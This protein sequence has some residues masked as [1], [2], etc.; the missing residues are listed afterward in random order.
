MDNYFNKV[1][2]KEGMFIAPQHF[3]QQ[4]R[5]I[6]KTISLGIDYLSESCLIGVTEL[7]INTE[8]LS[9]GKFC[10]TRC[11]GI[12]PDKTLFE[13][14]QE[15]VIDIDKTTINEIIY[16]AL[17]LSLVG[18]NEFSHK[19]K[20]TKRYFTSNINVFDNANDEN[21]NV[22]IDIGHLN[23]LLKTENQ[24]KSG[25]TLLPIAKVLE[26]KN[27]GEVIL[28]RNYI[29]ACIHH[30]ASKYINDKLRELHTLARYRSQNLMLRIENN[31][32]QQNQQYLVL[33]YIWLQTLNSWI[34]WLE[35]ALV[36]TKLHVSNIYLA[37][38][39]FL[40][41]LLSL[42][43][44]VIPE[45][46]QLKYD[47]LYEN[48][49]PLFTYLR[50]VLTIIQKETVIEHD[51]NDQLFAKR[52]I[53]QLLIN[54]THQYINQRVI[55]S[56]KSS[57]GKN[58]LQELFPSSATLCTKEKIVEWVKSSLSGIGFTLLDVV[59]AELKPMN[60]VAY[61][62]INNHDPQWQAYIKNNEILALH[63]DARIP[64]LSVKLYILG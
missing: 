28:D 12:F 52:R 1:V 51:W 47:K 20:S 22:D 3:Q 34:P 5:Y 18:N 49:H 21:N 2:W 35:F 27:T 55:I 62:E 43:A 48:F 32:N 42:S 58:L 53:L 25:F 44:K 39:R 33:D 64:D 14:S 6:N 36:N 8:L 10:I 29:A 41:E 11:A 60:N 40:G 26:C 56:V 15:I 4:E 46:A 54:D 7:V 61:F 38:Y 50:N 17:P 63:V 9:I 24:D 13:I 30:G 31:L 37:L 59:P 19:E 45:M 23:V 16:L 57:I